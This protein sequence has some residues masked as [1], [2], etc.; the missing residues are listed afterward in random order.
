MRKFTRI[1]FATLAFLFF[2][3]SPADTAELKVEWDGRSQVIEAGALTDEE[4][5]AKLGIALNADDSFRREKT[6]GLPVLKVRRA[7]SFGVSKDGETKI[8]RSSKETVGAALKEKG[9]FYRRGRMYPRPGAPLSEGLVIHLLGQQEYLV[10]HETDTEPEKEYIEDKNL[11]AGLERVVKKGSPGRAKVISAAHK[12]NTD[13]RRELTRHQLEPGEKTVIR[14]G[15][16]KSVKTPEGYKR[17]SKK[18]ICEATAYI[19]TGNRTSVGLWPYVGI[20]AVDPDYIPYYTKMYIPG[21]GLAIAGDTGGD[22]IHHRIDLFM[23][24]YEEAIRF[25]RRDV[26]VYI[27]ED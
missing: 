27:L 12:T 15:T 8:Y 9:I 25:G 16:A 1:F 19:A 6:D 18:M 10:E 2:G 11:A 21:Y 20:V 23:D 5:L 4:V 3:M 17:Y 22:I 24:S 14:Q 13:K 26:E 7:V